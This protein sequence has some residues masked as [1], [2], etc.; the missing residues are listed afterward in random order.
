MSP[1][2]FRIR[3]YE[4]VAPEQVRRAIQ[5]H[6]EALVGKTPAV[7]LARPWRS[8]TRIPC[9]TGDA[10]VKEYRHNRLRAACAAAGYPAR[11]CAGERAH[12]LLRERGLPVPPLLACVE[13]RGW[14]TAPAS[15]LLTRWL[16]EGVCL[17]P[18]LRST[19]EYLD[20]PEKL[21]PAWTALVR[22]LLQHLVRMQ[23]LDLF[24]TDYHAPNLVR[25]PQTANGTQQKTAELVLV[26]FDTVVSVPVDWRHRLLN[27]YTV[28]KTL[29]RDLQAPGRQFLVRTY[30]ELLY[31]GQPVR[32]ERFALLDELVQPFV[33]GR[34][35]RHRVQE[36]WRRE[37]DHFRTDP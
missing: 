23:G 10:A 35:I 34:E 29:T 16:S 31:P 19:P 18:L 2:A 9:G 7:V 28:R 24:M 11:A 8:I 4:D 27:L 1:P 30:L 12:R 6:R 5:A 36:C 15:F 20:E 33:T 32:E 37:R 25:V 14:G 13:E 21:N 26:D 22:E 3:C 17:W